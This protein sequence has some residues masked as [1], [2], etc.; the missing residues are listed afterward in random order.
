MNIFPGNNFES[1]N[2]ITTKQSIL[3]RKKFDLDNQNDKKD[4][5]MKA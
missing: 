2:S 4:N 3:K 1:L 5:K